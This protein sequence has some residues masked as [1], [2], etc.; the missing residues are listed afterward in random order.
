MSLHRWFSDRKLVHKLLIPTLLLL[1]VMGSVVWTARSALV[2]L[3]ASTGRVTEVV[4][5]RLAAALAIQSAMGEAMD[6]EA[7][8]LVAGTR[9][10]IDAAVAI[11][12]EDIAKALEGIDRLAAAYD[13]A[14]DREAVADIKTIVAEYE[15]VSQKAVEL[16]RSYD[17]DSAMRVSIDV[18][19]PVRQ[20]LTAALGERVDR[21]LEE[22]KMAEARALELSD[23][24]TTRLT[25]VAAAGLL[26]AIGLFGSIIAVFVVRPLHRLIA[27]MT[28]IAGGDLAVSV[29]GAERQDEVGLLARALAV[30]KE[31]GLAIRK[32][33][34][35]REA[36][37]QQAEEERKAGMRALA[38]RFDADV[39]DVVQAVASAA[40]HLRSNAE[41]M[42]A[43][44]GRTTEQA[45]T[46]AATTA[47]SSA[48][49]ATVAAASEQLGSSI[50]EIGRQV[51]AA[52]AIARN[53]VE[54]G[55]RTNALVTRLVQA[56]QR[57]GDVVSLIQ[58]IASQTNLLALNATIE[59]ARA[60][61]A[62][63]GF[64]VVA[65]EVK[66]LATQTARATEEIG[67]QIAE[68]QTVTDGTVGAIQSIGR[69]ITEVDTIAG[70]IAAAVEQQTAATHEIGRNIQQAA[71]GTQLV[72]GSITGV[73]SAA[74]EV[75]QA[76]SEVLGA[77][78][79]LSRD[80]DRLRDQIQTFIAEVR[81]A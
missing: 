57:I 18:G 34:E 5:G 2:E 10:R 26:V 76:A 38:D 50:G 44:A 73:S 42:T 29:R 65:Q 25:T 59:A 3:T 64:A 9:E 16:A 27:D 7:N 58:D 33:Q 32:L 75:G 30:F 49:V 67:S 45:S 4:A 15:R 31:N 21:S 40:R 17:T 43:V 60:G 46:V 37:K 39:Q 12:K 69:T 13:N 51:N 52:A 56:A 47:Q 8:A 14:A 48:N 66:A 23:S 6:A 63:K 78:D 61:E 55:A 24:V 19:R 11:Y 70:A 72:T 71:Q 77:A 62:G 80:S 22:T 68:I 81:A 36:Q 35:E 1:A 53:A 54:E 20:K 74:G 79:S 41:T 28:A